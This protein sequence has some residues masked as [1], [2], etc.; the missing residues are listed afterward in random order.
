[1]GSVPLL[2]FRLGS[3]QFAATFILALAL[4]LYFTPL[5]RR[6]AVRYGVVD[7]PDGK[8]KRQKEPVP[9]LGGVAI[10]LSFLFALAATYEFTAEVLAILLGGSIVVMLGLF[11]DLKV[12][13]PSVKLVGQIIAA[14]VL[15]KAGI[16]IR[17]AFLPEWLL[18]VLTVLWL[19]GMTNALNLIDVSDG[20]AG[21]VA[22]VAGIFLYVVSLW[23]H[24]TSIAM[25]TVALVGSTL[26]FLVFNRPPAR[27]YL[28]DTGSMF[29][30]FM[31][32]ALAMTGQ[33]TLNHRLAAL[34]PALILGLPIFDTLYVIGVRL[35]RRIPIM[36]GSPDHFAVRLRNHGL[37]AGL[38]AA[39]SYATSMIL[40]ILGLTLVWVRQE[41][42]FGIL[43]ALAVLAGLVVTLLWRIGRGPSD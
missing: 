19:V 3:F 16:M 4:S 43:V 15:M 17:L 33:Y 26:G 11:D 1:M 5:I 35:W 42:A 18:V 37:H 21:G 8:L 41:V 10:Y 27:I 39:I 32:G 38:I 22:A 34:A 20:L 6:G 9:Y 13:T 2:A 25:L 23:S 24:H 14:M 28:G 31:L 7:A 40:G 30:G 12:L 36:Q 29:L